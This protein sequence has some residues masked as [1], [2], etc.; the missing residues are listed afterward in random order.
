M[1]DV[2]R[3][4]VNKYWG[5]KALGYNYWNGAPFV[6]EPYNQSDWHFNGSRMV[7]RYAL[8]SVEV[9]GETYYKWSNYWYAC[10]KEFCTVSEQLDMAHIERV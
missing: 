7:P 5:G 3:A 2:K 10:P 9:D 1:Q 4:W 6:W 8:P